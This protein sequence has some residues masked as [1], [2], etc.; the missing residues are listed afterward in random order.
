VYHLTLCLR[1]ITRENERLPR[2]AGRRARAPPPPAPTPPHRA[3]AFPGFRL[4]IPGWF[5]VQ[6]FGFRVSGFALDAPAC[7]HSSAYS[8]CGGRDNRL[9][10]GETT[11][12][13]PEIQQ[14]TGPW[15][16]REREIEVDFACGGRS[17][18]AHCLKRA[19]CSCL[20]PSAAHSAATA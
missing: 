13:E 3:P 10:A 20:R 14:F 12:Y 9:R 11:G 16:E 17:A 5:R 4:D 15:C 19:R 2:G 8:S 7:P 6:V 1:V 18:R